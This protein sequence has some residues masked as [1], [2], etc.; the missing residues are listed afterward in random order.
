MPDLGAYA[1]PVLGSYGIGLLL[2]LLIVAFSIWQ[3]RQV[4]QK[5]A[6]IE[7]RYRG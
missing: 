7:A 5:L 2:L 4:K 3:A 1:W 6:M